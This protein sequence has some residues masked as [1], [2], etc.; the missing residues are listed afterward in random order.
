MTT[1]DAPPKDKFSRFWERMALNYPLPF[2]EK[3]LADTHFV[4]DL[5]K[6]RDVKIVDT[7]ILDIGCGTGIYTLPLAREAATVTGIDGSGAMLSRLNEVAAANRILNV[8]TIQAPWNDID[9]A[10]RE[11][12]KAFDIVWASMTPAVQSRDDFAAMER[13]AKKW[14]VYIGWGKKRK[15][16]LMEEVFAKHGLSY[17]PPPGVNVAYDML[18]AANKS[19]SIDYFE[20]SWGWAGSTADAMAEIEFFIELQ[21]EDPQRNLIEKVLARHG[22]NGRICHTTAVEQGVMV[23]PVD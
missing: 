13:C 5:V 6:K 20:T 22:Q 14:C 12:E 1:N 16:A 9:I 23:W 19:P 4:F 15:N 3:T 18:V 10:D 8:R 11:F 21:G 17:E 7:D 2:D